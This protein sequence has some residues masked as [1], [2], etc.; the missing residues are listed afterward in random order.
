MF[1]KVCVD[2]SEMQKSHRLLELKIKA[3]LFVDG[4]G[5]SLVLRSSD[6]NAGSEVESPFD[7]GD[8]HV[9]AAIH[10]T[11]EV[12]VPIIL[13]T[14]AVGLDIDAA[15]FQTNVQLLS[16]RQAYFGRVN[17]VSGVAE[18][19]EMTTTSGE[20]DNDGLT[21][22][23]EL[24]CSVPLDDK[25]VL[26]AARARHAAL[27]QRLLT[28]DEA[29]LSDAKRFRSHTAVV[30][31]HALQAHDGLQRTFM[32]WEPTLADGRRGVLIDEPLQWC[33]FF[34]GALRVFGC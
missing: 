23:S 6:T 27:A 20:R 8:A 9:L 4:G 3:I 11:A 18:P 26:A 32:P 5:D 7:G 22:L 16:E 31:Y 29:Q 13:A 28:L 10:Q 12:T 25:T 1:R 14:M 34:D 19:A 24:L 21:T 30:A 15:A 33:Y 17:L 2:R